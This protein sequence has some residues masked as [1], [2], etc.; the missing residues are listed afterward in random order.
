MLKDPKSYLHKFALGLGI[1]QGPLLLLLLANDLSTCSNRFEEN[2]FVDGTTSYNI[3]D[4]SGYT[5][6]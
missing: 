4:V 6:T 1:L 3:R 2:Y 5:A